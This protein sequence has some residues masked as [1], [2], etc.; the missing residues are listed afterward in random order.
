MNE[1]KHLLVIFVVYSFS[2]LY[3]CKSLVMAMFVYV[4][5]CTCYLLLVY[6]EDRMAPN[7]RG[8]QFLQISLPRVFTE[9]IFVDHSLVVTSVC[10]YYTSI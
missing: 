3:F 5:K 9:I 4:S 7:F 10:Y 2:G 1:S 6:S 8:G